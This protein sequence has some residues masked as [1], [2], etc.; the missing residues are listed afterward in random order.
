MKQLIFMGFV[1]LFGTKVSAQKF[2]ELALTPPMGWNSWNTFQTN[3]SEKLVM[4]TADSMVSSGMKDAGFKYIVLDDGWMAMERN[5]NGDLVPDPIKFPRG[6]KAVADYVHSKGLKFGLYN[7]AGTKT[8]A[9]YPGT[10]GYEYQDA[11]LYAAIGIDYLKFDWCSSDGQNAKESYTTMSKALAVAGRPVIFSLCEWG[12]NKPWE[13]AAS[14]GQLWRTTGDISNCFD[15][16]KDHGTWSQLGAMQIV[17]KQK[18][19]RKYAGPGHW[20]DPDMLEV[21]NGLTPQ[22][23]AAHFAI[24]CMMSAPLICGNDLRK[25]PKE[26]KNI[27]INAAIVAIDQDKLGVQGFPYFVKDSLEYWVKP[28]E[29]DALAICI[30]NRAIKNKTVNFEWKSYPIIDSLSKLN[31]DFTKTKYFIRDLNTQKENGTTA[32]VFKGN[33]LPHEAIVLRLTLTK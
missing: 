19:L 10:R 31:I 26:V 3:I 18:D 28:L 11:R 21:G 9:G 8:C 27:F 6:M 7:C 22:E 32:K 12:N 25:M 30:L 5:I 15:C 14:V 13:W 29:N 23:N 1:I 17:D 20:N 33:L 16:L 4:E 24:W 2:K